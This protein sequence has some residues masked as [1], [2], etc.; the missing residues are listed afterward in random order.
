MEDQTN[1][2]QNEESSQSPPLVKP[3]TEKTH[4]TC[5]E[6]ENLES[7][8]EDI[9]TE[10]PELVAQEQIF[11]GILTKLS[12]VEEGFNSLQKVVEKRLS[13]DRVKEGAFDLLCDELSELKKN[14][15]FEENKPLYIDLILLFDRVESIRRDISQQASISSENFSSIL[16]NLG[17]ELLEVLCRRGIEMIELGSQD[18][19]R[20]IQRAI[21]TEPTTVESENNQ[22]ARV[23][24]KGFK[25]QNGLLRAEEVIVKKLH[26]T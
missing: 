22:V 10:A 8:V 20:S 18:F 15:N 21:S 12:V 7:N 6:Q 14:A 23:V 16:E 25:H 17:D 9:A 2:G 1:F 24:R 3:D 26:T 5:K 4:T 19:D 11:K 13:D